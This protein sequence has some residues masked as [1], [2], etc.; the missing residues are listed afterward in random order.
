MSDAGE[1]AS[2]MGSGVTLGKPP[3][4][5]T[6]APAAANAPVVACISHR[7][8]LLTSGKVNREHCGLI[9]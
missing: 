5:N 9:L 3:A 7:Q 8:N 1:R 6:K 2:V 4:L